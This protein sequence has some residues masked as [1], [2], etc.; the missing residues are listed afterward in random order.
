LL[1]F[2]DQTPR[3]Y[4]LRGATPTL[5]FAT[6][7]GTIPDKTDSSFTA[8]IHLVASLLALR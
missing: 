1:L 2:V 3:A 7:P 6:S 5:G 8:M 4:R